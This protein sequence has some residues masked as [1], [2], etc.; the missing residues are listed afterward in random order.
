[1][2]MGQRSFGDGSMG[3]LG[4][5]FFLLV[6]EFF[7]FFMIFSFFPSFFYF[8][9]FKYEDEEDGEDIDADENFKR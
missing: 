7:S 4:L 8:F 2:M 3:D 9:D 6:F 5:G 1:M